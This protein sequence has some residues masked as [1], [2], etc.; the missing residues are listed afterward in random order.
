MLDVIEKCYGNYVYSNYD[1]GLLQSNNT[2]RGW[3]LRSSY[4]TTFT[5]HL[6][7]HKKNMVSHTKK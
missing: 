7:N 3:P 1:T 6:K 2:E 4:N 5:I